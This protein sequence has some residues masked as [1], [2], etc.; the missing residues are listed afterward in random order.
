MSPEFK[1]GESDAL[2]A[3]VTWGLNCTDSFG[4]GLDLPDVLL[5]I[6]WR[7]TCDMCTLW[8]R[9]GRAARAL[10]LTVFL[11]EPKRF[12]ANIAKAEA[13][14]L[15]RSEATKKRKLAAAD[16]ERPPS[17]CVAVAAPAAP[18]LPV[19]AP[20]AQATDVSQEDED[21][22]DCA[23][24]GSSASDHLDCQRRFVGGCP[25]CIV[26]CPTVCCELCTPD[27]FAEFA[28]VH[29]P[30]PKQQPSRTRIPDHVPDKDDFSLR[31]D[32]HT[33]RKER[34]IELLGRASFRN[35]GAGSIMPDE[36]LQRI[37]D[38][39][40]FHKITSAAD[41]VRETRWHRV[42]E[43]GVRVLSLISTHKPVPPPE[44]LVFNAPLRALDTN[45]AASTPKIS[46]APRQCRACF[47]L[48]HPPI[49]HCFL[50]L[51]SMAIK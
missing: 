23:D 25:R 3:G 49:L 21:T 19:P 37:I 27:H 42:V 22:I 50:R 11:V 12:D 26:K 48:S 10:H 30:K 33:F 16:A 43:D 6:Q 18:D 2:K 36:V 1:V 17:K 47:Q 35:H 44:P 32:L 28:W 4:M 9:I 20:V 13:R 8:K 41:L 39:S 29:I 46:K 45:S 34:T 24:N 51:S 15:K 7:S 38:C 5:V 31:A 14:V 40:H